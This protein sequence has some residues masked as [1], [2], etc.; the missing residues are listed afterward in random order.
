MEGVYLG[1]VGGWVGGEVRIGGK[2]KSREH[3]LYYD[4]VLSMNHY[5]ASSTSFVQET[6]IV[7]YSS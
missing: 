2:T 7:Q 3:C 5:L 6:L 4:F 1:W